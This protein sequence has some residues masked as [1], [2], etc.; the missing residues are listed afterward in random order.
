MMRACGSDWENAWQTVSIVLTG[1][2]EIAA[3]NLRHMGQDVCTDVLSFRYDPLPG[4]APLPTGEV[5]VNVEL[6]VTEGRK[7][8]KADPTWTPSLELALYLAHGCDHLAG[9]ND[10]TAAERRRMRRREL[11]WL[12][13]AEADH[14]LHPLPE[15]SDA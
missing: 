2:G 15:T 1:N 4:E 11:S 14:L 6:A 12:K 9:F 5:V 3:L 13:Q 8:Q 7:R 10:A